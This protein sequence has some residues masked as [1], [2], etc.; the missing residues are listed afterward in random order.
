MVLGPSCVRCGLYL[1]SRGC[2]PAKCM[3]PEGAAE[4]ERLRAEEETTDLA[5]FRA[6]LTRAGVPFA[7]RDLG[8]PEIV[9]DGF[10]VLGFRVDTG[11]L[12]SVRKL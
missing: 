10:G 4:L 11:A 6:M 8:Y 1:S 3:N 7:T 9:V 12:V 5:V 2:T